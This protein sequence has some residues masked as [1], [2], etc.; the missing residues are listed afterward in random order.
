[1]AP[2]GTYVSLSVWCGDMPP[3]GCELQ[4]STGRRYLVVGFSGRTL[5]CL[6]MR[7]DDPPGD[8]IRSW[9]W[10]SRNLP[11]RD[12]LA[13]LAAQIGRQMTTEPSV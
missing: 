7:P 12:A 13:R 9:T 10:G 6:V 4:T 11:R 5:R 8:P 3:F 1:M 2:A